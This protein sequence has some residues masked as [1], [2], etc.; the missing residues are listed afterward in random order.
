LGNK[1]R[2]IGVKGRFASRQA[3]PIDP[4]LQGMEPFQDMP[5]WNRGNMLRMKKEGSIMTVRATEVASREE[6]NRANPSR[7]VDERSLQETFDLDPHD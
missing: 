2:K 3:D 4:L 1:E 5:Q 6:E 7:P